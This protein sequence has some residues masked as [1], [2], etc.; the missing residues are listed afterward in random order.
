[1]EI[2]ESSSHFFGYKDNNPDNEVI[3][4]RM[5]VH[6]FGNTSSPAV[7][8]YGL[9]KTATIGE[10]QHGHDAREFVESD[11]YV[12]DDL[13]S[14]SNDEEAFDQ[15]RLTQLMLASANPRLHKIACSSSAVT[16]AFA[17]ED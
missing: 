6:V 10:L 16:Q 5:T 12:S 14:V 11:S 3:E 4:F 17:A 7:A 8:T 13:K 9:M 15:L 1:M 2:I